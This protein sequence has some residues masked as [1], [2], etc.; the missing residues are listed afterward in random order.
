[1]KGAALTLEEMRE[2]IA[3]HGLL[4]KMITREIQN[5]QE[6]TGVAPHIFHEDEL[7]PLIDRYFDDD[8]GGEEREDL[9]RKDKTKSDPNSDYAPLMDETEQVICDLIDLVADIVVGDSLDINELSRQ[10][11][12]LK[13][14]LNRLKRRARL[15]RICER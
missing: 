2:A 10:I 11:T 12:E 7:M 1:M 15:S 14:R 4:I 6:A 9:T 13:K 5:I 8:D 3:R